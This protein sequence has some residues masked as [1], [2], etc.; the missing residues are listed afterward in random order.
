MRYNME[1]LHKYLENNK[2][3][4]AKVIHFI[5]YADTTL[6]KKCLEDLKNSKY[7][8]YYEINNFKKRKMV[9]FMVL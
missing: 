8:G 4:L 3:F 6:D 1:N 7:N 2:V 9:K 5:D